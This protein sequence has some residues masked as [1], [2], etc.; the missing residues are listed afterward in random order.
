MLVL[1]RRAGETI[2]IGGGI[3]V[4]V[5]GV[6]G[7]GV[8]LGIW[9]PREVPVRRAELP[10]HDAEGHNDGLAETKESGHVFP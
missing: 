4:T 6:R 3:R 2:Q 8:R 1:S 9:A 10:Q 5:L 7:K